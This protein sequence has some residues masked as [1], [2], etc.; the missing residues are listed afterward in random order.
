[1]L[2][3]GGVLRLGA[4]RVC[5]WRVRRLRSMRSCGVGGRGSNGTIVPTLA[6]LWMF[7]PRRIGAGGEILKRV[8]NQN[9]RSK[10]L[11]RRTHETI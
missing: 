7:G 9:L 6:G 2:V 8:Q 3:G 11:W 10:W 4:S 5:L 1:M